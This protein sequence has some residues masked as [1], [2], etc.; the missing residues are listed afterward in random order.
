MVKLAWWKKGLLWGVVINTVLIY[1]KWEEDP[2]DTWGDY[3]FILVY[4]IAGLCIFYVENKLLQKKQAR[5]DSLS[6]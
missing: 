4:F 6:K 2:L 5:K 1:S 3:L